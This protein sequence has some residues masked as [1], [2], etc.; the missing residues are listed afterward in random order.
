MTRGTC[1]LCDR[2]ADTGESIQ[3]RGGLIHAS[4]TNCGA[5]GMYALG[6]RLSISGDAVAEADTV[7]AVRRFLLNYWHRRRGDN[8]P[9][10]FF[11]HKFKSGDEPPENFVSVSLSDL[12]SQEVP[13]VPLRIDHA[14]LRITQVYNQ[15]GSLIEMKDLAI[16]APLYLARDPDQLRWMVGQLQILGH[17]AGPSDEMEITAKGWERAGEVARGTHVAASPAQAFVA[18]A[19]SSHFTEQVYPDGIAPALMSAGYEPRVMFEHEHNGLIDDEIIVQ[20]RRSTFVVAELTHANAGAYY[21]AGFAQALDMDVIFCVSRD[22]FNAS[23]EG[24]GACPKCEH[25]PRIHFDVEHR[26]L[27][28]YDSPADLRVKLAARVEATIVPRTLL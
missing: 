2:E 20:I 3:V 14:L 7:F 4:W 8:A 13:P 19:F 28:I 25:R 27:I 22:F 12:L 11:V 16:K 21:E 24:D 26:S 1:Q 10:P 18:A 17:L 6:R 15:P 5:C 23:R 9:A